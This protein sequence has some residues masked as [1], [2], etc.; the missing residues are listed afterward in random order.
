MNGVR[1]LSMSSRFWTSLYE[2]VS[3]YLSDVWICNHVFRAVDV[4]RGGY[5]ITFLGRSV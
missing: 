1:Q 3:D 4:K 2:K 5:T